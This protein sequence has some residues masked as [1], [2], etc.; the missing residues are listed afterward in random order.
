MDKNQIFAR[1]LKQARQR[2]GL[3]MDALAKLTGNEVSKQTISKYEAG[4]TLAGSAVLCKLT[5]ALNVSFDYFF[6]PFSFDISEVEVSFR[7]KASVGVKE[8]TRLK[9]RIQEEV[10]KFIDIEKVLGLDTPQLS[11]DIPVVVNTPSQMK[12]LA[13]QLRDY[14]GLGTA[15]IPSVANLLISH[16]IKVFEINGPDGFDGISGKANDAIMVIVTNKDVQHPERNRLTLFHEL[17]HLIV[18]EAFSVKLTNYEKECLCNVFASEMLMPSA[19]LENAF[20]YKSQIAFQEL[21]KIQTTYGI[22]IDAVMY[23]LKRLGVVSDKR[24]RSYCIKKNIRPDFKG[25]VELSRYVATDSSIAY[26]SDSY[27]MLVYSA[28]AQDLITPVRACELLECDMTE[29]ETHNVAL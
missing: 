29:I 28:L 20:S 5:E 24:Y 1:R 26:S 27:K 8:I 13:M 11:L 3:T 10:E 7:K 9:I 22:S 4:K 25:A 21:V 19:I 17:A 12:G 2:M 14:W 15:P 6:K 16:G 18:N 23:S